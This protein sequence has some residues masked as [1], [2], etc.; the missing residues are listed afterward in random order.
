MNEAQANIWLQGETREETRRKVVDLLK[1]KQKAEQQI[2]LLI[3]PETL[4]DVRNVYSTTRLTTMRGAEA[5]KVPRTL[6]EL[7]RQVLRAG[8]ITICELERMTA[9]S[10]LTESEKTRLGLAEHIAAV[11]TESYTPGMAHYAHVAGRYRKSLRLR[12]QLS[13][14]VEK[15]GVRSEC[16]MYAKNKAEELGLLSRRR[17]SELGVEASRRLKE[18]D[19]LRVSGGAMAL[20]DEAVAQSDQLEMAL[21]LAESNIASDWD[22]VLPEGL[23]RAHAPD[24]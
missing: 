12:L 1:A 5:K 8:R 22:E 2:Q 18:V 19:V 24:V 15:L 21:A 11:R 16:A 13:R 20:V 14:M 23:V 10:P 4:E 17:V 3:A 9:L 6:V 7:R